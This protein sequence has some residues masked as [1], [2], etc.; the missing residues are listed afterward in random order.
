MT[1][2]PTRIQPPAKPLTTFAFLKAFVRNPLEVVPQAVYEQD[3]YLRP[4]G[5]TQRVWITSPALVKTVLLDE[6]EKF[7]KLSQI[8]LLSPLLG[9]GI[10]TSEGAEWKWQRQASAPMFRQQDLLGFVPAFVRATESLLAQWRTTPPGSEQPVDR[11]MTRATF[12]V[13]SATLLP[14]A[15]RTVG[16]AVEKAM[17]LFQRAGGWA[18]LF[19]TFGVPNWLPRPGM[20]SGARGTL[21]L[22]SAV[23]AMLRERRDIES[24]AGTGQDTAEGRVPDDLMHRLMRASD[25]ESG[26]SMNE[27]QLIDNLLTFYLA[28]HET[29]ARA[30]AWTLYLVA[31]APDWAAQ[32][33]EEIERV[34]GG[35]PVEA[36]HIERLVLVQQVVKESM[37]LYPPVPLLNRQCVA[38]V[39]LDGIDVRPGATVVVPIYA[40]HRHTKRWEDPDAFDPTR[41]A[42]EREAKIPRYQ[43]LPFGAGPRICIGMAFAMLE[44]TAMLA[45]LL[46]K[47]RFEPVPGRE[48]I[49]LARVTLQPGGGLPLKVTLR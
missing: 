1:L 45:T 38:P 11:D 28:G 32:L 23:A 12:D 16:M 44:A 35:G 9:K 39:R 33:E 18:L 30:L 40:I 34:T 43:Y 4:L 7:Q 46:Q 15:D 27:Q 20:V 17:Q 29:T 2:V 31:C 3:T 13:I 14:S 21:M 25:P 48:P 42:P 47:A 8:R 24:G 41:F 10:L 49:P 19:S 5:R 6:R 26:K 37:R 36:A 22:R